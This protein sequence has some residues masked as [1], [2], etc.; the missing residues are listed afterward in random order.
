MRK[1]V[2]L[3]TVISAS[4]SLAACSSSTVSVKN[5]PVTLQSTIE[6][7]KAAEEETE[8]EMVMTTAV[9]VAEEATTMVEETTA[10]EPGE[11]KA[12]QQDCFDGVKY[13]YDYTDDGSTIPL[14]KSFRD[15][16]D[17]IGWDI[18]V[19]YIPDEYGDL[20]GHECSDEWAFRLSVND[21]NITEDMLYDVM[22]H[23][24]D[25][26]GITVTDESFD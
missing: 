18:S 5:E 10:A 4:L 6:E 3:T 16:L 19:Y 22:R 26:F 11:L 13:D 2:L 14:S 9:Q 12:Y 24:G 17:S 21:E 23:V 7:T 25:E 20:V 1:K 8:N 15:Y